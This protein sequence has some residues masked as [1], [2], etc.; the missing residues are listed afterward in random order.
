MIFRRLFVYD[1]PF[2]SV[3]CEFSPEF[4]LGWAGKSPRVCADLTGR[5]VPA[6]ERA[7]FPI[8]LVRKLIRKFAE[9]SL[10]RE[11]LVG[12]LAERGIG[13]AESM[14]TILM[15]VRDALSEIELWDWF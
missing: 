2:R 1:P 3:P 12:S 5:F 13:K 15:M 4:L 14:R 8:Q 7:N 6:G 11:D 10:L 9:F